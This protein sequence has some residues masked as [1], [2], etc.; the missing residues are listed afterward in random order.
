MKKETLNLVQL[1]E[2]EAY[3]I[4]DDYLCLK[5]VNGGATTVY[6][7]QDPVMKI[8][9]HIIQMGRDSLKMELNNLLDITK[10]H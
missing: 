2:L 1:F 6:Y 7:Y 9:E 3:N 4:N 8:K 5:G 10:H